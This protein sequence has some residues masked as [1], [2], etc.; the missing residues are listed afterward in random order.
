MVAIYLTT[1]D[2][3]GKLTVHPDM[4]IVVILYCALYTLFQAAMLTYSC[5][6]RRSE[7]LY[8]GSRDPVVTWGFRLMV[9]G[10]LALAATVMAMVA[11]A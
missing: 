6:L 7:D 1:L 9:V 8:E 4:W 5:F 11:T 3:F 2:S 10:S